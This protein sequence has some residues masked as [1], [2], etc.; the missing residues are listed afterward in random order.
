VGLQ[1]NVPI[2]S[3]LQ[4][5]NQVRQAKIEVKKSDNILN[6][7]KN[8]INL[9]QE[10]ARVFYQNGIQSLKNQRS[11]MTLAR[12]VLRV[13]R[14]KYEQGVGSSL[15][16]TQAQTALETAENNYIQALYDAL[17]SKLDLDKAYGQIQ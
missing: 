4:R 6:S 2:F 3:G 5:L 13:S 11:N 8:A 7:V 10:Q 14:V 16:V 12:E 9:E 17:I 15:E 1:L